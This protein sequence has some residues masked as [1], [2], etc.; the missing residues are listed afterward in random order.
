[1]KIA[2]KGSVITAEIAS[3]DVPISQA[4]SIELPEQKMETVET[5]TL[6]NID[7]GIP[8]DPTGRT[9][10]GE[11]SC[12]LYL[13]PAAHSFFTDWLNETDYSLMKKNMGIQFGG[14]NSPSTWSFVAAGVS[15]GGKI[16]LND[17]IKANAKFKLDKT[18]TA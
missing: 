10:G 3:I 15:L 11:A 2:G 17:Y 13:D 9:E 4:I 12:E 16:A 14:G 5:D 1:M 6:D 8:H 7:A 18:A